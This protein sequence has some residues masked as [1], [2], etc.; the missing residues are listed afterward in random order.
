MTPHPLSHRKIPALERSRII[1]E[2]VGCSEPFA[3]IDAA[4]GFNAGEVVPCVLDE[5][6]RFSISNDDMRVVLLQLRRPG[7]RAV[8]QVIHPAPVATG[9]KVLTEDLR[10]LE[11]GGANKNDIRRLAQMREQKVLLIVG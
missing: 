6:G 9:N 10:G 8:P 2:P 7:K 11:R 1:G 3:P 5:R 4:C